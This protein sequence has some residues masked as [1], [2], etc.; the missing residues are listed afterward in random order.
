[1]KANA[2]ARARLLVVEDE[3]NVGRL[4]QRRLRRQ[5]FEVRVAFGGQAALGLLLRD[6]PPFEVVLLDL[7]MPGINGLEVLAR[8]RERH[9]AGRLAIIML[10]ARADSQMVVRALDAGADD[11]V[12]KPPDLQVLQ[13]RIRT[14][15]ERVRATCALAA[16][17]ERYALAAEGSSDALWD[18]SVE[19]GELYSSDRL[20]TILGDPPGGPA[21]GWA[22][23]EAR[24]HPADSGRFAAAIREHVGGVRDPLRL[25]H[26]LR[27]KDGSYAWVLLRGA[28][29]RDAAGQATRVAGSL[30]DVSDP[31]MHDS[32]TGL[33]NRHLF[34]D[35]LR[36]ALSD[37]RRRRGDGLAVLVAKVE[38]VDRITASHGTG[39]ADDVLSLI[40]EHLAD[41]LRDADG[42]SIAGLERDP[43]GSALARLARSEFAIF[44][45]GIRRPADAARIAERLQALFKRPVSVRG[46]EVVVSLSIGIALADGMS[47]PDGLVAQAT[48][49]LQQALDAAP[50]S[51]AIYNPA[52]QE[53]A[54]RRLRIEADLAIAVAQD[55]LFVEYQPIVDLQQPRVEG[56]EAL[57]RWRHP[58]FGVVGPNQFIPIAEETGLIVPLGTRVLET[59]CR[60]AASWRGGR[61]LR[62]AVNVSVEQFRD[63]HWTETV[64]RVLHETRLPPDRLELEVTETILA[65]EP[66]ALAEVVAELRALGVRI[67]IDDFGTGFSSFSYLRRF[68]LDTVKIDRSFVSGVP[69]G[70]EDSALVRAMLAMAHELGMQV[71]AEGVETEA[72]ASFLR[73][74]GCRFAQGWHFAKPMS[75]RGLADLLDG[76]DRRTP[77]ALRV[78][79]RVP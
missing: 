14:Q 69:T 67:A 30:T 23:W 34:K 26:R 3:P 49:A 57:V 39:F 54:R 60:A 31:R 50:G 48:G 62:V 61:E 8:V 42:V 74:H 24:V 55:Q 66:E 72:Q 70:V 25:E 78:A 16:S 65:K 44:C 77:M 51:H 2:A 5:G 40:A 53:E 37:L 10:T 1:V 15:L 79:A 35:R 9:P 33:P 28:A 41:A 45:R 12:A 36:T 7:M 43:A 4:I 13:A 76:S 17:E 11:Y 59:A 32:Q 71:V 38:R 64:R 68:P 27:R 21:L 75:Q 63:P 73:E 18:W 6:D 19:T 56:F 47:Y 52:E 22:E 58:E 29:V 20:R 46:E